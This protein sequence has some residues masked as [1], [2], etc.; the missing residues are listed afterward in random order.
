MDSPHQI[1]ENG[2]NGIGVGRFVAGDHQGAPHDVA[3]K[4]GKLRTH[5]HDDVLATAS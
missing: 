4:E 2:V 1:V 3:A 5:R